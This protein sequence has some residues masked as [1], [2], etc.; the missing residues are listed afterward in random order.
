MI[1]P[2]IITTYA[3]YLWFLFGWNKNYGWTT[4]IFYS[5]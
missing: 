3:L 5:H 4:K 1:I 2:S